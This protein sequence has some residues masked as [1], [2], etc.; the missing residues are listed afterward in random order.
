MQA[1]ARSLADMA[2][3]SLV[4]LSKFTLLSSTALPAATGSTQVANGFID[5]WGRLYA[6]Y[7]RAST[8]TN[9]TWSSYVL[10][11]A[12]PEG[13]MGISLNATSGLI[14]ISNAAQEAD[15]IYAN[16]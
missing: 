8:T 3:K 7:Y 14:T 16:R 15:N 6:Y 13:N 10:V 4:D 12:G 1:G 5:P 2:G 9:S 11:S